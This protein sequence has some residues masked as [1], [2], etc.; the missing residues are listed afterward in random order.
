MFVDKNSI[1]QFLLE[2]VDIILQSYQ[3]EITILKGDIQ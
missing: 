3:Q 2:N 1:E